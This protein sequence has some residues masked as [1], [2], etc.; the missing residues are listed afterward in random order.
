M[1]FVFIDR[2][3]AVNPKRRDPRTVPKRSWSMRSMRNWVISTALMW[4]VPMAIV[5]CEMLREY[6]NS[7]WQSAL[8]VIL[9]ALLA[10]FGVAVPLCGKLAKRSRI[11]EDD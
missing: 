11:F 10:G 8:G 3:L 1:D 6:G 7:T 5:L 9:L 4:G 2:S